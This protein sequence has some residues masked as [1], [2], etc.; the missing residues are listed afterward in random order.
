MS[1]LTAL[2]IPAVYVP[3]A[4]GNGEQRL[5]AAEAVRAGGASGRGRRVHPGVGRRRLVPL[6]RDRARLA[7]MGASAASIG[8]LDGADRMVELVREALAGRVN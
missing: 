7:E 4:V 1:E 2:G 3:F 5:N 6:L 8:V